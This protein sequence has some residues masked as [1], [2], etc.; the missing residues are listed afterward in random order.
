[1]GV[2]KYKYFIIIVLTFF[3]GLLVSPKTSFAVQ[4]G[5]TGQ[6]FIS[7]CIDEWPVCKPVSE[8][9][10]FGCYDN[11]DGKGC[12]TTYEWAGCYWQGEPD[13]CK[14]EANNVTVSCDGSGGDPGPGGAGYVYTRCPAG[15]ALSCGTTTEAA[16]QNKTDCLYRK[17]CN[18]YFWPSSV[19]L[20]CGAQNPITA[21]C[22]WNCSCCPLGSSRT[23]T[24]GSQYTK[25]ITIDMAWDTAQREALKVTCNTHDDIF[26]NNDCLPIGQGCNTYENRWGDNLQD[27]RLTC[28]TNTCSCVAPPTPTPWIRVNVKNP[29]GTPVNSSGICGVDCSGSVCIPKPTGSVYCPN[30]ARNNYTFPKFT[31]TNTYLGGK[32]AL[33]DNL[34][35]PFSVIGVTPSASGFAETTCNGLGGYCYIWNKNGWTTGG[36]TVDFI[37]ASPTPTTTP[38]RTPTPTVTPT[39]SPTIPVVA[40]PWIKLKDTSFI[41]ANALDNNIPAVPA[42]YD[43]DDTAQRYFIIHKEYLDLTKSGGV[44]IAPGTININGAQASEKNW[45]AGG[46]NYDSY[47]MTP[48][49]FL[50]YIKARKQHEVINSLSQIDADGIYI[51]TTPSNINAKPAFYGQY[52]VVLIVQ[53]AVNINVNLT[54]AN[55]KSLAIVADQINFGNTTTLMEGIFIANEISTGDNITQGLKI[56]G[57][58]IHQSPTSLVNGRKWVNQN[59]P[60]IFIVFD[61]QKYID[62]LPYLSTANYNWTQIQ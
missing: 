48:D 8:I 16:T 55:N 57:N 22:N 54:P 33:T 20:G 27:W 7:A 31:A 1:M 44:V 50:N 47:S 10:K 34:A 62:L 42:T 38:T 3:G 61:P 14:R 5:D 6:E 19:G 9:K 4:C 37:V 39:P 53:G 24:Q 32:I 41:S 43:G 17:T 49:K 18:K 11:D 15:Q 13:V 29:T 23:C 36:R 46:Y 40:G 26:V 2:S 52:N 25:N 58:L 21:T 60:S 30:G 45:R 35:R 56:I 59:M 28:R 12:V 51:W